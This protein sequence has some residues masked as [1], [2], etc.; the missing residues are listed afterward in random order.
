MIAIGYYFFPWISDDL[1]FRSPI[2]SYFTEGADIDWSKIWDKMYETHT[3]SNSRLAN[4]AMLFLMLTPAWFYAFLTAIACGVTI[5]YALVSCFKRPGLFET[6]LFCFLFAFMMPW[7]DELYVFD[8]ALNYLFAGAFMTYF[9][10]MCM[11]CKPNLFIAFII[12]VIF[13]AWQEALSFP[14]FVSLTVIIAFYKRYR[15]STNIVALIG[16]FAGLAW[17]Y[18]SPGRQAYYAGATHSFDIRLNI[19][20]IFAIPSIIYTICFIAK[21]TRR[22]CVCALELYLCITSVVSAAMMIYASAGPRIGWASV[23]ASIM[24]LTIYLSNMIKPRR[25]ITRRCL[26]VFFLCLITIHLVA[27]DCY[28][29]KEKKAYDYLKEQFTKNPDGVYFADFTLRTHAGILALQK[30]YYDLFGHNANLIAFSYFYGGNGKI[31]KAL[32]YAL[33]DFDIEKARAIGNG[34]Y[35]YEGYIIGKPADMSP[36]ITELMA[37]YGRGTRIFPYLTVNFHAKDGHDYAWYNLDYS[38]LESV[39]SPIPKSL[40]RA[41]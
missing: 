4:F 12:G 21:S 8:F 20:F 14:T 17:L 35:D 11:K 28:A 22:K 37:D 36:G 25:K 16:L 29:Y 6:S 23:L 13:G 3:G 41:N 38:T 18:F 24:G 7:V 5:Y 40:H 33:K 31:I 32:P 30:P 9:C 26:T 10:Y 39:I 27:V 15:T 1:H 34:F 19:L 2:S